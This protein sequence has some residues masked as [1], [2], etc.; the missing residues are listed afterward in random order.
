MDKALLLSR[1]PSPRS[2]VLMR[3]TA[4]PLGGSSWQSSRAATVLA[5]LDTSKY[6]PWCPSSFIYLGGGQAGSGATGT[7]HK[8]S[9]SPELWVRPTT[10]GPGTG[11]CSPAC[12]RH[13]ASAWLG[14]WP[15]Q[16]PVCLH[17]PGSLGQ[18]SGEQGRVRGQ[19][20]EWRGSLYPLAWALHCTSRAHIPK[21]KMSTAV[22]SATSEREEHVGRRQTGRGGAGAWGIPH[23]PPYSGGKK[24]KF[25]CSS[26]SARMGLR[27]SSGSA[28]DSAGL[29]GQRKREPHPTSPTPGCPTH[30]WRRCDATLHHR[31]KEFSQGCGDRGTP[32]KDL[33]VPHPTHPSPATAPQH[34]SQF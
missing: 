14:Q 17:W 22:L 18:P 28:V 4:A 33:G 2:P 27:R 25:R 8:A 16:S 11:L 15:P 19:G 24:C 5:S 34:Q 31:G 9:L 26:C 7:G 20:S 13:S 29:S 21:E 23:S 6:G 10:A 12:W 3:L 1:L 30:R 32:A